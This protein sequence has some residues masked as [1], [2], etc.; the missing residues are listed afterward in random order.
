MSL[1][2]YLEQK[3]LNNNISITDLLRTAL[4]V[5]IKLDVQEFEEWINN[6]LNGYKDVDS[7]MIPKYRFIAGEA[8]Y[9]NPYHGWCDVLWE[10]QKQYDSFNNVAIREKI[11]EIEGFASSDGVLSRDFSVDVQR[12]FSKNNYGMVPKLIFGKHSFTGI[13]DS[14][15]NNI[16]KWVLDLERKGVLGDDMVFNEK[17]RQTAGNITINNYI[18]HV[19]HSYLQQ[20]QDACMNI[21]SGYDRTKMVKDLISEIKKVLPQVENKSDRA[22]INADITTI[23]QQLKSPRPKFG[24]VYELLG[25]IRNVMEGAGGNLLASCPA[26]VEEFKSIFG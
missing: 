19:E 24:I 8:K 20:G 2:I 26:I 16:L 5:A 4:A 23:E 11:S 21:N 3:A 14:V 22:E 18:G 12:Y 17:E 15:R 10:N 1:I 25:S 6:E 7:S 9:Y 13:I